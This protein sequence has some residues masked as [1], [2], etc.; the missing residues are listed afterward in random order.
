VPPVDAVEV[1]VVAGAVV[2]DVVAAS[3]RNP[4]PWAGGADDAGAATATA[5]P[6]A[7]SR[8]V[9]SHSRERRG[10]ERTKETPESDGGKP[11][12]RA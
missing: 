7:A 2:L 6:V 8:P 3:A 12:K 4:V 1:P 9:A 11:T 5:S 10:D